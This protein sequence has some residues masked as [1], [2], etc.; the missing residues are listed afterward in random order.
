MRKPFLEIGRFW[1]GTFRSSGLW[2]HDGKVR[3]PHIRF[4]GFG[5]DVGDGGDLHTGV[6]YNSAPILAEDDLA[7]LAAKDMLS[8]FRDDIFGGRPDDIFGVVGSQPRASKLVSHLAEQIELAAPA[9]PRFT[10]S[11][12]KK[13]V[14]GKSTLIFSGHEQSL[15]IGKSVLICQDVIVTGRNI[16]LA[17][18]SVERA[19][20]RAMPFIFSMVNLSG[21]PSIGGRKIVSLVDDQVPTFHATEC[22][23]CR[24][25]SE[26]L[27]PDLEESWSRLTMKY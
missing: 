23:L 4:G 24:W 5:E 9:E 3:R 21:L 11:P 15:V 13:Q 26:A 8:L 18:D 10:A 19:G 20:G 27:D 12:R 7:K 1:A 16:D 2:V 17:V 14:D 25:G 22:N 6:F